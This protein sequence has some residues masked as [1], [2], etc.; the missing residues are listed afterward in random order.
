MTN[1][2]RVARVAFLAI[3]F[4]V[5]GAGLSLIDAIGLAGIGIALFAIA[6]TVFFGLYGAGHATK[7]VLTATFVMVYFAVLAA[8]S[9]TDA[10]D[11]TLGDEL[12]TEL[13]TNFSWLVGVVVISYF[14]SE[15]ANQVAATLRGQP[16]APESSTLTAEAAPADPST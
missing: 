11:A 16:P 13:W 12:G 1:S 5:V 15:S 6:A 2:S 14:G 10:L 3:L 8:I 4:W 7:L 9:M